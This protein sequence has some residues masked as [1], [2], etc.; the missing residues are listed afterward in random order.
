MVF[1]NAEIKQ[2]L[3]QSAQNFKQEKDKFQKFAII[4]KY[5]EFLKATPS[6]LSNNLKRKTPLWE[7]L[8]AMSGPCGSRTRDLLGA[9][10][11]L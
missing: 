3:K 6:L 7:A 11:A 1:P 10:E 8:V 9:N 5:L 4:Y 2:K